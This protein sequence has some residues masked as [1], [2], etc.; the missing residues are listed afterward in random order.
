M[1]ELI[2]GDLGDLQL[3]WEQLIELGGIID[4]AELGGG[5]N[6]GMNSWEWDFV[7]AILRKCGDSPDELDIQK[8]LTN[9]VCN[10]ID[11]V[12]QKFQDRS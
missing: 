4:E 10:K 6:L 8:A 3:P 1:T 12:Y 5:A 9:K 11:Q 7:V 2:V